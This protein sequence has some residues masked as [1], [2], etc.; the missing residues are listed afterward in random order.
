MKEA[1]CGFPHALQENTRTAS[2]SDQDLSDSSSTAHP[3]IRR[4]MFCT[5]ATSQNKPQKINIPGSCF[6]YRHFSTADINTGF[7]GN[8]EHARAKGCIKEKS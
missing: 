5:L 4:C 1:C 6:I 7:Y 8:C 3:N 2:P